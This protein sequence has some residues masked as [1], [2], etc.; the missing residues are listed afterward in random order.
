MTEGRTLLLGLAPFWGS[1]SFFHTPTSVH[2]LAP[3]EAVLCQL[4]FSFTPGWRAVPGSSHTP[5]IG[6]TH[7]CCRLGIPPDS[8]IPSSLQ[9]QSGVLLPAAGV[10]HISHR[11]F[12][13]T[14]PL[15]SVGRSEQDLY[16]CVS[17]APRGAGVSNFAELIV[18]GQQIGLV[19]GRSC[20]GG[21]GAG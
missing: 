10:R 7:I 15:T 3:P 4:G 14:F 16:R 17:Q 13:A 6:G 9:R 1:E 5:G 2:R 21:V 19:E 12:L 8:P 20:R 18:K 11:R